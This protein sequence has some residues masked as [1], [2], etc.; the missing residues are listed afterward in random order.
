MRRVRPPGWRQAVRFGARVCGRN[1][2][3][4]NRCGTPSP[5]SRNSAV[6]IIRWWN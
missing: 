4:P 2:A 1:L 5:A 6:Q 3:R